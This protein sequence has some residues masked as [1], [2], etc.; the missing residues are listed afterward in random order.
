MMMLRTRRLRSVPGPLRD[1]LGSGRS[2]RGQSL[3]VFAVVIMAALIMTAGL[4]IDGGQKAAAISRA[5]SAAAAVARVG[6]EAGA[7]GSVAGRADS[8]T[9]LAAATSYLRST[10]GVR[11]SASILDGRVSAHTE[12]HVNTIFLSV[13]GIDVLTGTGDASSELVGSGRR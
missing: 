4:V 2:A 6:S 13:I 9:A 10:P 5:E 8:G 12:V 3:T 1:V 7:A 11:G